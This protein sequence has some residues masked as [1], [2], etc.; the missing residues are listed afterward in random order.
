M[1]KTIVYCL[2]MLCPYLLS[3]QTYELNFDAR[4]VKS[5]G[6]LKKG[7]SVHIKSMTHDVKFDE[8]SGSIMITGSGN[9]KVIDSYTLNTDQ[10]DVTVKEKLEKVL[11][12]NYRD[13]QNFWDVQIIYNVL[14]QLSK[15]GTQVE[16]RAEMEEDALEYIN[17][18]QSYGLA[19]DDPYLESYIYG[20]ISKLAPSILIDGRPGNVNLLI[21]RNPIA[22][23]M[24]FP[25]G[26][27]VITTGL[28]SLLHSEDELAAILSHEIA[29]F[30][31]DHSV[32][33][34]NKMVS[35][36]KRAEFWAGLATIL[37]AA[38]EV[39]VA[40]NNSYYKPGIATV[41]VAAASSQIATE[42]CKR[43]GMV[44][45]RKQESE[46]D[47]MAIELLKIMKYD[48]NALSTAL[49]RIEETLK[50]ERSHEMYFASDHP[51]LNIRIAK[52]GIPSKIVDKNFEKIISFAVS[53]AATMKMQD[54]RFRQAM[55]LVSQNINN[56]VATADD[57]IQKA[58]CL[59]YLRNDESTHSEVTSLIN[60]AKKLAP[61]NINIHKTEILALLRQKNYG[62]AKSLLATYKERL[63]K[64]R[65]SDNNRPED[66]WSIA[67]K[68]ATSELVWADDMSM[69][70]RSF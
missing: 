1:K 19:F 64:M 38:T 33:N 52:A 30:V 14:E 12:V 3:A 60:E 54:R 24:M 15:K 13:A 51:A 4:V 53:D 59:L 25:N 57:Y 50:Q 49:S 16:L 29:H 27:L 62:G 63:L 65:S 47:D 22:N 55:P 18:V 23:A 6:V 28:I 48:P 58:N 67:Y 26:T 66:I 21:Q 31:L 9:V 36:A 35:R 42:V 2:F 69:K 40:A 46:A 56:N 44:Y 61:N 41:A 43:L 17:R 34:Y 39:A 32:Q 70:L 10:G 5:F 7:S 37:T 11:D 45:N 68:F 8:T 20:V